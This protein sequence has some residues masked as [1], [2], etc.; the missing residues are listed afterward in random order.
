LNHSEAV[1]LHD[2]GEVSRLI[3]VGHDPHRPYRIRA[4]LIRTPYELA[5][6]ARDG[7][8]LTPLETAAAARR[9][10]L[11][12]LLLDEGAIPSPEQ[13]RALTC[14]GGDPAVTATLLRWPARPVT[15]C[16]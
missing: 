9:A 14:T 11:V 2:A 3:A 5:D 12:Q 10:E 8:D 13:W 6:V 15:G 16:P 4:G 7:I 1:A